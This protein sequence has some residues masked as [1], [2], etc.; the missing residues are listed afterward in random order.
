MTVHGWFAAMLALFAGLSVG[1]FLTFRWCARTVE[2]GRPVYAGLISG[3][4][5]GSAVAAV[6]VVIIWCVAVWSGVT[7]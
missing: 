6:M 7:S 4:C 2:T 1:A 3:L 5:I